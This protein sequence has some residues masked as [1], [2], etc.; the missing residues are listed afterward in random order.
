M[1]G[2]RDLLMGFPVMDWLLPRLTQWV[3]KLIHQEVVPGCGHWIQRE[4]AD[5]V[6]D[7]LLG[8]LSRLSAD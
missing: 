5:W 1:V 2:D 8:F 7:R 6:N 3:P 4:R